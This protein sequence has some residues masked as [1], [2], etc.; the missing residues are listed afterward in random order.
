[1][2]AD[3]RRDLLGVTLHQAERGRDGAAQADQP[4]L[5]VL[6]LEPRHVQPMVDGGGAEVPQD[7]VAI[8]RQQRP[9]A[10]L[11]AFPLADL[12][13]GDVADVVDV[14]DQQGAELGI[15][16]G[17]LD[18]A[19]AIP[20]QA[21]V[22]DALLEID[23]HG[24]Q[25]RKSAPPVVA[26]VD[27]LGADFLRL[28]V[29]LV[30]WGLPSAYGL[31]AA[32]SGA[33]ECDYSSLPAIERPTLQRLRQSA[34]GL[35]PA[36]KARETARPGGGMSIRFACIAALRALAPVAAALMLLAAAAAQPSPQPPS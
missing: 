29:D 16:Q 35:T 30:H 34:G 24:P 9:A 25:G 31:V 1:R 18:A 28:D 20:V 33:A 32:P 6:R 19:Q 11:V 26:R 21:P 27:V 17:L 10:Q 36:P 3:E 4:G 2:L 14:E 15:L 23:P 5:A 7:R 12:G 8:A 13:R 22:V